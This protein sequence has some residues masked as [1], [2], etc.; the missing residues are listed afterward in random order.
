MMFGTGR[1]IDLKSEDFNKLAKLYLGQH[2]V[3]SETPED[4]LARFIEV[5]SRMEQRFDEEQKEYHKQHPVSIPQA[6]L[7]LR[8]TDNRS[9]HLTP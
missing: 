6:A 1:K 7:A 2:I 3:K 4:F 5:R 9:I 8:D